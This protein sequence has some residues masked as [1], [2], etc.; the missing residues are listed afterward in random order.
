[1]G[2]KLM[3]TTPFYIANERTGVYPNG[4]DEYKDYSGAFDSTRP[5][6]KSPNDKSKHGSF[7]IKVRIHKDKTTGEYPRITNYFGK[8]KV[9]QVTGQLDVSAYT[10]RDG[11][12]TPQAEIK[13]PSFGFIPKPA[14]EDPYATEEDSGSNIQVAV[15]SA[16]SNPWAESESA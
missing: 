8:G 15:E 16:E 11:H 5:D 7:W 6:P 10:D 2:M 13:Y 4:G 9:I 1:M 3:V 12:A 14:E